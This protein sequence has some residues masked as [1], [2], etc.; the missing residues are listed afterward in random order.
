MIQVNKIWITM[1]LQNVLLKESKQL[2][3]QSQSSANCHV[4]YCIYDTRNQQFANTSGT[5]HMHIT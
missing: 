4:I 3:F 1:N 5:G 2:I